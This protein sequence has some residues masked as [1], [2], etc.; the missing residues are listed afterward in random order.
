MKYENVQKL[1]IKY[2]QDPKVIYLEEI[3]NAA[4]RSGNFKK[5]FEFQ[6]ELEAIW[7]N[8]LKEI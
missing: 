4:V 7:F 2:R 1:K 8:Y 3:R 5:A 6:E